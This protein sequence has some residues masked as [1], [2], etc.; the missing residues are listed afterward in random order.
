[1]FKNLII[2]CKN[3]VLLLYLSVTCKTKSK[4]IGVSSL[5]QKR[6]KRKTGNMSYLASNR[7]IAEAWQEKQHLM[8]LKKVFKDNLRRKTRLLRCPQNEQVSS[9]FCVSFMFDLSLMTSKS[10]R[11]V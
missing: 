7:L 4:R 6:K 8:H 2:V 9:N 11:K 1:M 5:K 10:V 3:N